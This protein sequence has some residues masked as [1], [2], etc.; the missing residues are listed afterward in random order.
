MMW[1][2]PTYGMAKLYS[3]QTRPVGCY[4]DG[5]YLLGPYVICNEYIYIYIRM[6]PDVPG[7]FQ[8]FPDT[9]GQMSYRE[10]G[11]HNRRSSI[12]AAVHSNTQWPYRHIHILGPNSHNVKCVYP[13]TRIYTHA[14][15]F[16][17][18]YFTVHESFHLAEE[19]V[20]F[21]ERPLRTPGSSH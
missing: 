16:C 2:F 7:C 8:M 14:Y 19:H 12:V 1:Y 3:C 5:P 13:Y 6:L 21:V 4:D 9:S 11:S 18:G 15:S 10:P 17:K 20:L